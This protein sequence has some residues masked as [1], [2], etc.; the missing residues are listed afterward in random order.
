[1]TTETRI[2]AANEAMAAIA[3]QMASDGERREK[4]RAIWQP[5]AFALID[6]SR[7]L[8]QTAADAHDAGA[9]PN[10]VGLTCDTKRE[11]FLQKEKSATGFVYRKFCLGDRRSQ[12]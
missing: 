10:F 12:P 3:D 11:V 5:L 8:P 1:M 7:D 4:M 9:D 6:T 2:E